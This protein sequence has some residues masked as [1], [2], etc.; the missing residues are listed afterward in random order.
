M[1]DVILINGTLLNKIQIVYE[2]SYFDASMAFSG[3]LREDVT[4]YLFVLIF[5]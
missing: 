5:G 2:D 1:S 4:I 3:N